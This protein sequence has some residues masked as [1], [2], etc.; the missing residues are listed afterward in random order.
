[1]LRLCRFVQSSK[2]QAMREM[3]RSS[4]KAQ[5]HVTD[6]QEIARLKMLAIVG[7]Q[8]YVVFEQ[9]GCAASTT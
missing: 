6:P 5:K 9:T 7:V 1:M 4:F 2:G 3:I 8:N